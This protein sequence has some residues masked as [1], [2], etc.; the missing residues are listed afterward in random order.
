MRRLADMVSSSDLEDEVVS[1]DKLSTILGIA[2]KKLG[3][4]Y[5]RTSDAYYAATLL[6][7]ALKIE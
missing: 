2:E 3:E 4:Y 5:D 7:P 1:K 6:N